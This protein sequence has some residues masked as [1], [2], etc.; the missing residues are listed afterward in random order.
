LR[1][2]AQVVEDQ[3]RLHACES[4][5]RIDLDQPVQVLGEVDDDGDVAG[6]SGKAG[7]AAVGEYR[8]AVVAADAHRLD[9][10]VGRPRNHDPNRKLPVVRTACRVERAVTGPEPHLAF[11]GA[12]EIVLETAHVDVL[13]GC[14]WRRETRGRGG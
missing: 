3:A 10:V 13:E 12:H 2:P 6:L 11:Y 9:D 1:R 4:L 7:A 8:R 5:L 14:R